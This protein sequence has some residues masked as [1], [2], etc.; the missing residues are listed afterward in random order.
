MGQCGLIKFLSLH[1]GQLFGLNIITIFNGHILAD[2]LPCEKLQI[3][4]QVG[5]I[6]EDNS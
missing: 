3:Q 6:N 4:I 5:G 1:C 2:L